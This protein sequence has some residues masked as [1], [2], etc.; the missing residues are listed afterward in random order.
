MI[1]KLRGT[2]GA[3]GTDDIDSSHELP[4]D[5]E[6][7]LERLVQAIAALPTSAQ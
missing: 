5:Q 6:Q 2:D 4:A 7:C 3:C 1:R